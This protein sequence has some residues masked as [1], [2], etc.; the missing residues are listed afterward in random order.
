MSPFKI[1]GF[2]NKRRNEGT[3]HRFFPKTELNKNKNTDNM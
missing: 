2:N 3:A 1:N